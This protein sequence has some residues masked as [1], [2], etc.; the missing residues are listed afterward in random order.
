MK[1]R[2]PTFIFIVALLFGCKAKDMAKIDPEKCI[3]ATKIN[4][5]FP[6][7][8]KFEPVCGCDEKSYPNK[9][10]AERAGV[11]HYVKGQ[12]KDKESSEK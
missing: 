7:E 5:K 11:L 9:C 2:I 3:D 1:L 6:C 12:C 4:L 8:R 10:Y